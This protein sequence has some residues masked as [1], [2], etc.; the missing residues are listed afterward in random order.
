MEQKIKAQ[1]FT[2]DQIFKDTA[3]V[4]VDMDFMLP[5]YCP[6]VVK[7]L[8]CRAK[9]HIS[10]QTV[11]GGTVTPEGTVTV[12]VLYADENNRIFA[13]SQGFPFAK[14]FETGAPAEE[15]TP[16]CHARVEYMN[17][18]AVT[19]RK[20]DVH[21]AVELCLCVTARRSLEILADYDD[22]QLELRRTTVPAT[23]PM[24]SAQKYVA[25]EDEIAVGAGQPAICSLLRYSAEPLVTESK[26]LNG[27]NIVKGELGLWLLYAPREGKPQSV[28][29]T[30][31]FSQLIEVPGA[32]DECTC[33]ATAC[34]AAMEIKSKIGADGEARSFTVNGK[35]LV[36]SKAYCDKEITVVTDAYS[37]KCETEADVQEVNL[38]RMSRVLEESCRCRAVLEFPNGSPSEV[39]DLCCEVQNATAVCGENDITVSGTVMAA[40][41]VCN[42][43]GMPE[44]YEK[45]IEFSCKYAVQVS[46]NASCKP[47]VTVKNCSYSLD[48]GKAEIRIEL[49]I[50]AAVM[51]TY[52][53]RVVAD[54]STC[55]DRPLEQKDRGAMT[56]Y[57]AS[58]GESVW[59]IARKYRAGGAEI[60]ALNDVEEGLTE[61]KMLMIPMM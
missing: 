61:N 12:S 26:L 40:L 29:A 47:A 37:R 60:T 14:S 3:E 44:Y 9:V 5:D 56:L 30:L 42:E 36:C 21:G 7:I 55:P 48:E 20:I 51:V 46:E 8:K 35:L 33:N 49:C 18:R 13:F 59:D 31:P 58:A 57:F 50:R 34:V 2:E 23:T 25:I 22:T 41:L 38:R 11:S 1:L 27:K 10:A 24:G 19:G 17:C 4:P 52:H 15:I 16:E 54:L 43:K 39:L 32:T 53:C 28:R 45:P 6:D